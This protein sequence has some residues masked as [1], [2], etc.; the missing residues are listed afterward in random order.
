MSELEPIEIIAAFDECMIST[1]GTAGKRSSPFREDE[2]TA[3]AWIE[4]GVTLTKCVIVFAAQM[5]LMRS[6]R[7]RLPRALKIFDSN[8]MDAIAGDQYDLPPWECEYSRWRARCRAWLKN[9]S[10]WIENHWG[11]E[12]FTNGH[13]VPRVVLLELDE[14]K[15]RFAGLKKAERGLSTSSASL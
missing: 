5:E 8:I 3:Q 10:S 14:E 11:P 15:G 4:A 7:L 1:W 2:A 13:R 9:P 6:R 12:P